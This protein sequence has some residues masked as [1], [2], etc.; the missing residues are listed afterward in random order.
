VK[1]PEKVREAIRLAVKLHN[2]ANAGSS[3]GVP[4]PPVS[5]WGAVAP[6]GRK[7]GAGGSLMQRLQDLEGLVTRG[8]LQRTEAEE[9]KVGRAQSVFVVCLAILDNGPACANGPLLFLLA[10]RED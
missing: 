6:A 9:L 5:A 4:K 2:G 3:Y 1:E 7:G 8:V 10:L